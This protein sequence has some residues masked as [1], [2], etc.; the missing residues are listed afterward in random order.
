MMRERLASAS[1]TW[2]SAEDGECFFTGAGL[3]C[4]V[5]DDLENQSS[6]TFARHYLT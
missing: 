6:P 3:L 1:L 4:R 5:P 2:L